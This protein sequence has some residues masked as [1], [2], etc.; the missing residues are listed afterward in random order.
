MSPFNKSSSISVDPL[1]F[2]P[3]GTGRNLGNVAFTSD[4][5]NASGQ[6]FSCAVPKTLKI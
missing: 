3:R 1:V 5:F 4:S 6:L 2:S